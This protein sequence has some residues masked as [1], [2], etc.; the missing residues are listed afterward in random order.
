MCFTHQITVIDMVFI[1]KIYFDLQEL[2]AKR[3]EIINWSP[4]FELFG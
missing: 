4:V 3:L 1:C 2:R